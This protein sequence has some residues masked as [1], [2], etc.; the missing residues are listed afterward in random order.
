MW[1]IV[2]PA[3]NEASNLPALAACL[4]A[5]TVRPPITWVIVDDASTD[6]T[7][8][9]AQAL[10]TPFR[11]SVL[12]R[13]QGGAGLAGGAAFS[14][15]MAGVTHGLSLLSEPPHRVLKLDADVLLPA[16]Y[17]A[18][19]T[20]LLQTRPL[21]ALTGGLVGTSGSREQRHHVPGATKCYSWEAFQLVQTLPVAVAFDVMDE[22]LLGSHGLEVIPLEQ[23]RVS[24]ARRTGSSEGLLVGRHR[25]GRVIRWS[26]YHPL[27]AMLHVLR[28]AF[29]RPLIIGSFAMLLGAYRAG[30][31]PYPVALRRRHAAMQR[32]K[33]RALVG[34]PMGWLRDTY[35]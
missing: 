20:D 4:A 21:V 33:L 24:V 2:T 23:P 32:Q 9:V 30:P 25:N 5:Q 27:Y 18:A 26:G 22:V 10:E 17:F 16:D 12:R 31:G 7:L 35:G 6:E 13:D 11:A 14:A 1:L 15:W 34:N 8:L 19:L 28:Y 29:R 3:H